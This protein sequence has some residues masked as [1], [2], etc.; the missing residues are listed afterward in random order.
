MIVHRESN[1]KGQTCLYLGEYLSYSHYDYEQ[2]RLEIR[3]KE[4]GDRWTFNL[5]DN[6][7]YNKFINEVDNRTIRIFNEFNNNRIIGNK[8]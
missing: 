6:K 1:S 2:K 8:H 7:L 3:Y 4:T 5:V